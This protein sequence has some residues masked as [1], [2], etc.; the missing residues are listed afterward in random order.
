VTMRAMSATYPR[1]ARRSILLTAVLAAFLGLAIGPVAHP[2]PTNAGTADYMEGLIVKWVN[3]AR[4]N[5]GIP[6]LDVGPKLTR[7]AGDR[8]WTLAQTGSLAHPS[9]LGCVFQNYGISFRTCGEVLAMNSY[10]WGWQAART[11]FLTWKHSPGHWGILMSRAYH[12]IGVGVSYRA[13]D[14]T[15]WAAGDLAG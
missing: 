3:N 15:T 6:R 5:R 9:C 4:A 12:R 1:P 13:S 8:A 7:L 10:P 11:I 2:A 14:H